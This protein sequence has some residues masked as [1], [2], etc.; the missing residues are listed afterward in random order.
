MPPY[1]LTEDRRSTR[2]ANRRAAIAR[3]LRRDR[4]DE[5]AVRGEG[6]H[7]LRA[8]GEPAR[9]AH[10]AVR[11]QGDRRPAREARGAS[12]GRQDAGGARLHRGDL[13]ASLLG[14]GGRVPV[15]EV[16]GRRH[17]ARPRD[18][19]HRRGDGDR[20]GLRARLRQGADRGGQ[21]PAFVGHGAGLGATRGPRRD[22]R[23]RA[24]AG[25][26]RLPGARDAGH[27]R[28]AARARRR[29]RD[30][31]EGRG[32]ARPTWCSGSRRATSTS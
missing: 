16:P 27:R 24:R 21:Q 2:S 20:F 30:G 6:R 23:R 22:L 29:G 12:D 9:L 10:G 32:R 17:A 13:A 14:E 7:R 31:P 28:G 11:Q 18:A 15:R 26:Q 8:R 3:E 19:E 4:P 25:G 1:S 5:R